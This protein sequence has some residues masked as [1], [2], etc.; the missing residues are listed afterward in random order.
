M[1]KRFMNWLPVTI[2]ASLFV[3]AAVAAE[4][5]LPAVNGPYLGDMA[6]NLYQITN[7]YHRL[8]GISTSA[9]LSVSQTVGQ[10]NCTQLGLNGMQEITTSAA[11][12]YVCLPTAYSGKMIVIANATGQ[13]INIY[14]SNTF[15][16]PGTQDNINTVVGSTAYANLTTHKTAICSSA[17]NGNW[18]CATSN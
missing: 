6:N 13:T 15:F 8:S 2:A 4:L 3:I 5:P 1:F 12:G 17:S 11:A 10:A 14:G 7:A 9:G 16:T 18:Y